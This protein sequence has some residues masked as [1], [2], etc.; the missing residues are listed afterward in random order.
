MSILGLSYI[1]QGAYFSEFKLILPLLRSCLGILRGHIALVD[2]L[3][4]RR[5]SIVTG[6][7]DGKVRLWSLKTIALVHAMATSDGG[8]NSLQFDHRRIASGSNNGLAKVWVNQTGEIVREFGELSDA[9]LWLHVSESTA[10]IIK[11]YRDKIFTDVSSSTPP[12][13]KRCADWSQEYSF[14]LNLGFTIRNSRFFAEEVLVEPEGV[15]LKR[16]IFVE[17]ELV[18]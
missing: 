2:L 16:R 9:V 14:E 12:Y 8:M 11:T 1:N 4:L 5:D 18:D 10:V 17:S 3:Q 7:P 13:L 15:R 6:G